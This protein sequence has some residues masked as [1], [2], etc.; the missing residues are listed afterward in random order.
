ME[1]ISEGPF[2]VGIL[3][4]DNHL[5]VA[6][7]PFNMP[8]QADESGDPDMLTCLKAYIKRRYD[9]PG[10]VYL[11]LVHRLDRPAGGVMVFARTS[12]AAGRLSEQ[13]SHHLQGRHY[14][15]VTRGT[16]GGTYSFEDHLRKDPDGFVRVVSK[17]APGAKYA[18]L[19]SACLASKDDLTLRDAELFTGRAHQ[20]RVQHASRGCPLYGDARY[21]GGKPGQQLALWA[22]SL[23]LEHPTRHDE[24]TFACPP[25]D[26][27]PWSLFADAIAAGGYTESSPE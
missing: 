13:F 20:I 8:S 23:T 12:K 26:A 4:E 5:L 2:R 7:K 14:L 19:T 16:A 25:P 18:R 11:G 1:Y 10:D 9:K 24:M 27:F 3:Y 22:V 21:G 15:L 6:V 17:D